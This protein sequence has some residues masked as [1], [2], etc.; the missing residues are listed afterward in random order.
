MTL[1]VI[2]I[3]CST[4]F[5]PGRKTFEAQTCI[6]NLMNKRCIVVYTFFAENGV[7]LISWVPTTLVEPDF[8]GNIT[9]KGHDTV[10]SLSAGDDTRPV[11]A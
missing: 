5:V 8:Q 6:T 4:Y 2:L 10:V 9:C 1:H 7:N 3:R 11:E